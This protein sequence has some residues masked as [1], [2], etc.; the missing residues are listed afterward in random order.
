MAT[1]EEK[2]KID[3]VYCFRKQPALYAVY[4]SSPNSECSVVYLPRSAAF[5]IQAHTSVLSA[6]QFFVI[7][8]KAAQ[9]SPVAS[10]TKKGMGFATTRIG[11]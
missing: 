7:S 10:K 6:R 11:A 2:K 1:S 8:C 9:P 4:E 3:L 5:L